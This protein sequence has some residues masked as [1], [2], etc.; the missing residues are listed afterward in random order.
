MK[1]LCLEGIANNKSIK[2]L[3]LVGNEFDKTGAAALVQAMT[4][5]K[6]LVTV[7]LGNNRKLGMSGITTTA[8]VLK[9]KY[10]VSKLVMT[11]SK[12]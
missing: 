9:S 5:H 11:R 2:E 7:D 3:D 4:D 1:L 8:E 6:S 12:K 10:L